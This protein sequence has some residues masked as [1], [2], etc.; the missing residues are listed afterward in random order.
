MFII[1]ISVSSPLSTPQPLFLNQKTVFIK[2][3]MPK[4]FENQINLQP[5]VRWGQQMDK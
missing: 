4:Y 1:P 3:F 5:E 2:S